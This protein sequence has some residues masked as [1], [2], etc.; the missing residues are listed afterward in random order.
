MRVVFIVIGGSAGLV[1]GAI[2][3]FCVALVAMS[4]SQSR[5]DGSYGMLE[6]IV[7]LPSGTFLG[8][9]TGLYDPSRGP[10]ARTRPVLARGPG[11]GCPRKCGKDSRRIKRPLTIKPLTSS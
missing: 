11:I 8:L 5:N 7:C 1:I 9:L 2:A 10:L 6:M 3:G 4:F